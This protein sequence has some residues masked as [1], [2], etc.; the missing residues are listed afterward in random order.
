MHLTATQ[1]V[2]LALVALGFMGLME[3]FT[4]VAVL[5]VAQGL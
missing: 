1:A 5:A 3:P 2:L 4:L